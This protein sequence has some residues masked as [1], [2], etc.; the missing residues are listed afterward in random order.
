M[1]T[2]RT[3]V[4]IIGGG[5]AGL[6]C[7]IALGQK[8]VDV[9]LLERSSWPVDKVCGEGLMPSGVDCLDRLGVLQR[10]DPAQMRPFVGIRW[11]DS[12]G[13]EASGRFAS[14][15]ALGIRRLGLSAALY[16][17]A[18]SLP[19]VRLR[20]RAQ[21]SDFDEQD[22]AVIIRYRRDEDEVELHTKLLIGADGRRSIVR[23]TM[24]LDGTPPVAARRWGVRQHFKVR[25]WSDEVEVYWSDGVEAYVTPS[26][27]ERIEVAF[28]WDADRFMPDPKGR[29][30]FSGLLRRFPEL[31]RRIGAADELSSVKATG[32]LASQSS[33]P[34]TARTLLV[35]DALGYVDGITGEGISVALEQAEIIGELTPGWLAESRLDARGL[36]AIGELVQTAYLN[37]VPLV[38]LALVLTR[39]AWLRRLAVRGLSRAPG[40]FSH[41]LE[42]NMGRRAAWPPPLRSVL[43]FAVGILF[44]KKQPVR[45]Q[46]YTEVLEFIES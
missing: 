36:D 27:D 23:R 10:I 40:L 3:E 24:Q 41:I 16:E 43:R 22:D 30:L 39:Y 11:I 31:S 26:S 42:V 25:P 2:E 46:K 4:A 18:Q 45:T 6:A 9:T 5:P 19:S 7:A 21:V 15:T 44:P 34:N 13:Q 32:P 17:T 33:V 14:G 20:E 37:T 35:G 38:K 12:T 28:L 29:Q 8:G 1:I